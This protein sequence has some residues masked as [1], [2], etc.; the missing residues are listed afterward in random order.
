LAGREDAE[1]DVV[2]ER[3]VGGGWEGG[4]LPAAAREEEDNLDVVKTVQSVGRQRCG[5][6]TAA[7]GGRGELRQGRRRRAS[8]L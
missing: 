8:E 5:C 6:W 3:E 7:R 4:A 1:E 2:E